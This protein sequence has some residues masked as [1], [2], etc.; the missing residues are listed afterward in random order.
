MAGALCLTIAFSRQSG[1]QLELDRDVPRIVSGVYPAERAE[2]LTFAWTSGRA[3][4]VLNGADRRV[5]WVCTVRFRG[6]RAAPLPQPVVDLS[7]DGIR[8]TS[9]VASNDYQD[10]E[11]AAPPRERDGLI[12][13]LSASPTV[14]PGPE[15]RR[16]LGVQLD[17]VACRPSGEGIAL[18]PRR[19]MLHATLAAAIFGATISFI[20]V[21]AVSAVGAT[22]LLAAA[23]ALPLSTGPAPFSAYSGLAVRLALWIGLATVAAVMVARRRTPGRRLRNTAKF[24]IALSAA[25]LYLQLLAL[26]HPSKTIVD[27]VFQAHRL[28]WVLSGRLLFTQPLGS[29]VQF[30]YAIGLY[31]FAAPFAWLTTDHVALLRIV[32]CA[33]EIVAG[34][35]LYVMVVR[36]WGDRLA[37]AM[38]VALFS[39][40][41][42]KYVFIGSANL[43]NVFG[44]SVA[45]AAMAAL[46]ILSLRAGRPFEVAGFA[47]LAAW[48]FLC[49]VSTVATLMT[50]VAITLGL[51]RVAGGPALRGPAR[52]ALVATLAAAVLSV[53]VYYGHF[54]DVYRN[55]LRLRAQ[56]A[57]VEATAPPAASEPSG[58]SSKYRTFTPLPVRVRD[59]AALTIRSV[60]WPILVLAGGGA[61]QLWRRRGRDRLVFAVLGWTATYLVFLAVAL[62]RVDTQYQR[63]SYEFVGRLTYAT[64]PAA[65]LLA[66]L[67]AAWA[68]R[69]GRVARVAS[70]ALLLAAVAVGVRNWLSWLQ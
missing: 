6:G 29:G 20:D 50:T 24:V 65:V 11:V 37:G 3:Q 58:G 69:A 57:A 22:L 43:T 55:A 28:E 66:A 40:V 39:L 12:F 36:A 13:G 56:G 60:G 25:V 64:Y 48:A 19:T 59:A 46:T 61:W 4:M 63:Y 38:A 27:A 49:H 54:G 7:I 30:P 16:E 5:P 68:W 10:V 26:L 31:V 70:A 44:Q 15:D 62:M 41:P 53:A 14:V 23:Q 1:L 21:I 67:G 32:V 17:R 34:T 9:V 45:L 42:M 47:A 51:Y 8:V 52:R 33:A 35:L 18:P 2:N